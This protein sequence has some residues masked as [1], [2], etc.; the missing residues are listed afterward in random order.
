VFQALTASGEI[1]HSDSRI[2]LLDLRPVSPNEIN[3]AGQPS[4][5][6]RALF[7]IAATAESFRSKLRSPF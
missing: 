6:V 5:V 1:Y 7:P 2:L 3:V 4:A